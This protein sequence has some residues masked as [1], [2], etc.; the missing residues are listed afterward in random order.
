MKLKDKL[1][2]MKN[3]VIDYSQEV[4][5]VKDLSAE[6]YAAYYG[7]NY[8]N[9][10]KAVNTKVFLAISERNTEKESMDEEKANESITIEMQL[11][12]I[13]NGK[14]MFDEP[15]YLGA[16]EE[17]DKKIVGFLLAKNGMSSHIDTERNVLVIE[18]TTIIDKITEKVESVGYTLK[19]AGEL[20]TDKAIEFYNDN[21]DKA[22][23]V[24]EG[25][26]EKVKDTIKRSLKKA[27]DWVDN[28]L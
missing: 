7:G 16:K 10:L 26:K 6:E 15:S 25:S 1:N 17:L 5:D 8:T 28:N 4:A 18:T 11:S 22:K 13:K 24:Y 3:T 19:G 9:F 14:F 20:A 2:E 12:S 21:K 27:S 23:E